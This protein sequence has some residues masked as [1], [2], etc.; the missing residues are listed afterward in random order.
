MLDNMNTYL[1]E[2]IIELVNWCDNEA[3]PNFDDTF[4]RSVATQMEQG[5][6]ISAK[7]RFAIERIYEEWYL[8]DMEYKR[9]NEKD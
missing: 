1:K 2:R 3:P 9:L 4:V 6:N 7:Q 5:R 8:R